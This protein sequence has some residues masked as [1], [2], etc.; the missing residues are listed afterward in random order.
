MLVLHVIVQHAFGAE[1]R[2]TIRALERPQLLVHCVKMLEGLGV[3]GILSKPTQIQP[4]ALVPC[5]P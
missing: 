3:N 2:L 4:Q 5:E 1:I